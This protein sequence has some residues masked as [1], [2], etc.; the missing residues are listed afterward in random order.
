MRIR[1]ILFGIKNS[2]HTG[3]YRARKH[4]YF[5]LHKIIRDLYHI[6]FVPVKWHAITQKHI[7]KLVLYWQ[8][9]QIQPS[10]IMKYMTVFRGFLQK[11]DHKLTSIENHSLGITQSK[12]S[13]DFI[14]ISESISDKFSSPTAKLLFAFQA[15]FGLTL[16]EAM[17]LVPDIHIQENNL[18][19]TREIASS[20]YDRFIPIRN[21]DQIK[22]IQLFQSLCRQDQ[23][24]ISTFGYHHVRESYS[25]Q[26][27][28]LG[29]TS[30]KTYRYLYAR[31]V[32]KELTNS[33]S[34]Y[35]VCQTIMREMGIQSRMTLWSYLNE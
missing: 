22:I 8:S 33:L 18:W 29:L 14:D 27:T 34:N 21:H 9:K 16:S 35:L 11:I 28:S 6:D 5:V 30:S 1:N 10:T 13:R 7:Q 2:L 24:L 17:R 4:R 3:S 19:I 20:S 23:N 26:L 31:M 15:F 12:K 25:L 32:H